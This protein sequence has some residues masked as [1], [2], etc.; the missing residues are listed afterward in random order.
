MSK[1]W[2]R[3][4]FTG[5]NVSNKSEMDRA[6]ERKIKG[7]MLLSRKPVSFLGDVNTD[8]VIVAEDSDVRGESVRGRIFAFPS[9]R[10]STV[11]TYVILQL[12][13]LG[14]APV[15]I[16]NRKTESI[17]AAGAVI[18]GIPLFDTP[19][20]DLFKLEPGVYEVEI[21]VEGGEGVLKVKG[22]RNVM[23]Y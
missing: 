23:R 20:P 14:N 21:F 16:V 17:I 22:Q 6:G 19:K 9:G 1:F 2:L 18:A 13:R 10:G 5:G 3:V 15:A 7:E 4:V 8:G 11:G 12:S